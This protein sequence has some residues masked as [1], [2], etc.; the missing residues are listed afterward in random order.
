MSVFFAHFR[1]FKKSS[2]KKPVQEG[3]IGLEITLKGFLCAQA[4]PYLNGIVLNRKTRSSTQP[5]SPRSVLLFIGRQ[6]PLDAA[7]QDRPPGLFNR[8]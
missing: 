3:G 8:F 2:H 4:H 6:H 1:R 7:E 5:S